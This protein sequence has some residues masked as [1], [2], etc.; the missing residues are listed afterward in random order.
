VSDLQC[1]ARIL[2]VREVPAGALAERLSAERL[3]ATYEA[4]VDLDEVADRPRG[5][6]VLV[7]GRRPA[8]H[9]HGGSPVV[10]VEI[11]AD[12]RRTS[13]WDVGSGEVRHT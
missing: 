9:D 8:E 1:A 10:L 2:L 7:V 11:D 3:A 5:E 4:P 12:G 6:T 13:T